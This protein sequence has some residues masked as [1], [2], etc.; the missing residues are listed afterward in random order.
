MAADVFSEYQIADIA[1]PFGGWASRVQ[2]A[3]MRPILAI[4]VVEICRSHLVALQRLWHESR[5][6][7]FPSTGYPAQ[8]E[9]N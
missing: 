8:P 5:Y 9:E 7:F 4:W 3:R 2:P 6:V 1:P